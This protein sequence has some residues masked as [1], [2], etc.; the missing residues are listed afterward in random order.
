MGKLYFYSDQVNETPGNRRLDELLFSGGNKK[1]SYIP[2]TEDKEKHYYGTKVNYYRNYGIEN[3]MFF[4]LY[5]GFEPMK[6]DELL[7]SDI[8]HLSAGN[9]LEFS[10][11]LN[12][13]HMDH[14]LLDFYNR[15][16]ILVGVSGGAVQLGRSTK[17]FQMFTETTSEA[18]HQTLGLVDFEFLPHYNRWSSDYKNKIWEYAKRTGTTVYAANDGDG[19][20]FEEGKLQ[21]IGDIVVM[22]SEL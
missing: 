10:K 20:I 13:R 1:I 22:K 2:S 6:I 3:I 5:S 19:I 9:P 18:L 16:G 14:V 17:L 12:H 21:M 8:I 7:S 15:G 11:A 4:D